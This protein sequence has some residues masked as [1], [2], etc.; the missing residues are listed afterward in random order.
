M[1]CIHLTGRLGN[2]LFQYAAVLGLAFKLN[3]IPVFYDTGMLDNVLHLDPETSIAAGGGQYRQRCDQAKGL[4]EKKCCRLNGFFLTINPKVDVRVSQY[5]Q[6]WKYFE[7]FEENVRQAMR[8]KE[9]VVKQAAEVL[10]DLRKTSNS[11]LVGVHVRRG[12]YLANKHV[13]LG[14]VT[15]PARFYL[16]AMSYMRK[17]FGNV[18]FFVSTDSAKWFKENVTS[19]PDVFLLKR[20]SAEVDMALLSSM[21]HT[22]ISVGTYSWWVGFLNSGVTVYWKD[23]IAAGTYIGNNFDPDGSTFIYPGWIPM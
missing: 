7:G 19:S 10:R 6:S 23:F 11:T 15:A 14:Y 9:D 2:Q 3:R 22:I 13:R 5:M 12:D 16:D 17:R 21:D 20:R 1:I 8:F 4:H 18:T